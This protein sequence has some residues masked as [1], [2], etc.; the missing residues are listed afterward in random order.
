MHGRKCSE[1]KQKMMVDLPDLRPASERRYPQRFEATH[2][3]IS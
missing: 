3:K 2:L 1:T